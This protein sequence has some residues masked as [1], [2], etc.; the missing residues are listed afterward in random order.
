MEEKAL[1][2]AFE[3][4]K[5]IRK[6]AY[7]PYSGF[8]VGAA[9]TD[10]GGNLY[11]GCNVE[12]ASYGATICAERNAVLQAVGDGVTSGFRALVIVSDST[13]PAPPCALCLQVLAEFC[14]QDLTVC[15]ADLDGIQERLT[16]KELLPRP[17]NQK[18]LTEDANG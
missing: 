16:L 15:L 17:F 1:Q 14:S 3:A 2:S 7:T 10:R 6:R 5:T 11:T 4:A 8:K 13:P 12:N 18:S 9:L